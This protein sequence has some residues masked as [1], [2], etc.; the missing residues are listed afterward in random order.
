M[1]Y[2]V[3]GG[4]PQ[5]RAYE[6]VLR[7]AVHFDAS[8]FRA[9]PEQA[10]AALAR[11]GWEAAILTDVEQDPA[12]LLECAL[13]GG[14]PL[15][16]GCPTALDSAQAA[17]VQRALPAQA[18]A[19][20]VG[21]SGPVNPGLAALR[22]E[23]AQSHSSPAPVS[24]SVEHQLPLAGD[25]DAVAA[26]ILDSA[27]TIAHLAGGWPQRVC[28]VADTPHLPGAAALIATLLC[29]TGVTVGLNVGTGPGTSSRRVRLVTRGAT[30]V[31]EEAGGTGALFV[32]ADEE[33]LA[34][35]GGEN[36]SRIALGRRRLPVPVTDPKPAIVERFLRRIHNG[37]ADDLATLIHGLTLSEHLLHSAQQGGQ[38]LDVL[39][40]ADVRESP[41][42]QLIRGGRAGAQPAPSRAPRPSLN[43]V[44][45]GLDTA[46]QHGA[47]LRP[48]AWSG[49]PRASG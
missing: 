13:A 34:A 23:L 35:A 33:P 9:A 47:P 10:Q 19:V 30:F 27:V 1:R 18:G 2:L 14:I 49:R 37:G 15:L 46:A 8:V 16:I 26:A 32:E 21:F 29:D 45:Y 4:G 17:A 11:G 41:R 42:L 44:S 38:T 20:T 39:Y 25:G 48:A 36:F 5:A 6:Q 43:I 3:V 12:P 24:I 31:L 28:G 40:R 22:L 7:H